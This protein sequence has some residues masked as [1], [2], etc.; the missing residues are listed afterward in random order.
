MASEG[1]VVDEIACLLDQCSPSELENILQQIEIGD[2]NSPEVERPVGDESPLQPP[3]NAQVLPPAG[4]PPGGAG[5]RPVPAGV[6]EQQITLSEAKKLLENHSSA[7]LSQVQEMVSPRGISSRNSETL[8]LDTLTKVLALRD[9]E[10]QDLETQLSTAQA[11]LSTKDRRIGDLGCEL[12][13]VI[14]EF[15]HQQLDLEF[16]QLKLEETVR[17]NFELEQAQ[18]S[19]V[20]R[21]EEAGLNARH[22]ALDVDM[23]RTTPGSG[24]V[25]VQGSL[26]WTMRKNRTG[27]SI[28]FS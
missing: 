1:D 12:D 7:V 27:A 5:R 15:R 8:G 26:P 3:S 4:P 9:E 23:G 6:R 22:A 20:A 13:L 19:L 16:Q 11:E 17:S 2:L 18:R 21:V 14:R 25:R 28:G 10:V 24:L